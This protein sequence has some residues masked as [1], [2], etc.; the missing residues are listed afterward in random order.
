MG[1]LT[2]RT[3][4][5]VL[6]DLPTDGVDK[7]I[8]ARV[9]GVGL[10]D[11]HSRWWHDIHDLVAMASDPDA[12]KPGHGKKAQSLLEC[13]D[14]LDLPETLNLSSYYHDLAKGVITV[15]PGSS[16]SFQRLSAEERIE[17]FIEFCRLIKEPWNS[18]KAVAAAK[19]E[20]E[21]ESP[22]QDESL[23]SMEN[24]QST[25]PSGHHEQSYL[26]SR[27]RSEIEEAIE[28][29]ESAVR[30]GHET[31]TA[32]GGSLSSTYE[33]LSKLYLT[34][35]QDWLLQKLK[36]FVR[37]VPKRYTPTFSDVLAETLTPSANN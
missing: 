30:S 3:L 7:W 6:S 16:T 1:L 28:D 17:G 13:L 15:R 19:M 5:E 31:A 37:D 24:A 29:L 18:A 4:A 23:L 20:I 14:K 33:Q 32:T 11:E 10:V 22:D 2:H 8:Q 26:I 27:T 25:P 12:F 35:N 36:A 21:Q 34:H 9:S